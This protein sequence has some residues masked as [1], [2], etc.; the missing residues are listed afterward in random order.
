MKWWVVVLIIL[1][2]VLRLWRINTDLLIHFDQ[3][4]HAF[5]SYQIWHDHQ[6]KLLGHQTDVD[7]L[8]HG[9]FYYLLMSI[10]Y[11]ISGGN[12]VNASVFQILMEM[13]TLPLFYLAIK[14]LLFGQR[15]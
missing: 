12:P 14:K 6:F 8:F 5:G 4:L 10:P 7:G 1:A 11:G 13:M 2:G 9:P 15:S 3:G